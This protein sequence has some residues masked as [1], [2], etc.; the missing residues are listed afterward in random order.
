MYLKCAGGSLLL[1]HQLSRNNNS[2]KRL[3]FEI[4]Q[5]HYSDQSDTIL[6]ER[7]ACV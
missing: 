2:S 5:K 7:F 6:P 1:E 3:A 4:L